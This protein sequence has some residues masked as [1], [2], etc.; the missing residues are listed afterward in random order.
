MNN[1]AMTSYELEKKMNLIQSLIDDA[2]TDEKAEA[3]EEEYD[4]LAD[5]YDEA[6]EAEFE[7]QE[8]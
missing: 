7:E 6:L 4:I 8:G 2:E 3:L 1:Y 5:M